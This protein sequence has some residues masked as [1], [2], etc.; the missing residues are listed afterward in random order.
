MDHQAVT[1]H[2]KETLGEAVVSGAFNGL[3]AGGY[4]ALYVLLAG[5]VV[6]DSDWA[7]VSY[8][9]LS[10]S[11]SPWQIIAIQLA[12]S[13]ACGAFF[14]LA[15]HWSRPLH[16]NLA[17][18]WLVGLAYGII[19][20]FLTAGLILPVDRFTLNPLAAVYLLFAYMV[21]GLVLGAMKKP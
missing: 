11:G 13:A 3:L 4:L 1:D 17:P 19:L 16:E 15:F 7:Y 12:V 14:G 2:K 18:P 10:H 20:W 6:A 5:M 9:D 21:Y 8:F